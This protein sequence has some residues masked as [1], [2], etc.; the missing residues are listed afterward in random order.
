VGPTSWLVA[1][2]APRSDPQNHRRQA[3]RRDRRTGT[4]KCAGQVGRVQVPR[5][6]F[7]LLP[8]G[9]SYR[10]DHTVYCFRLRDVCSGAIPNQ[11]L[12]RSICVCAINFTT[13]F[14]RKPGYLNGNKEFFCSETRSCNEFDNTTSEVFR[15]VPVWG[16]RK[17][18][19]SC[20]GPFKFQLHT[21]T[22]IRQRWPERQ[23][24]CIN[25]ARPILQWCSSR[26]SDP[27]ARMLL[28]LKRAHTHQYRPHYIPIYI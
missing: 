24:N 27:G 5:C 10:V 16:H 22:L 26:P 8:P 25:S 7:A 3:H 19:L 1:E 6:R 17:I 20:S 9:R 12:A 23:S 15:R 28:R 13:L 4:C 11:W 14:I 2:Q 18:L 21:R